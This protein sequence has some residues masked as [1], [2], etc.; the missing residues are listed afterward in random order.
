MLFVGLVFNANSA[1]WGG[2]VEKNA[3]DFRLEE[4]VQVGML[5]ILEKRVDVAVSGILSLSI[6]ADISVPFLVLSA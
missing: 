2:F 1:R 3:D 5:S 4:D 6:W